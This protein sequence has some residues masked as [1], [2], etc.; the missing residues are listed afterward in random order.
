[1]NLINVKK[2][3]YFKLA[4]IFLLGSIL[5]TWYEV[6]LNLIISGTLE[7]RSSVF[8]GPFNVIYGFAFLMAVVLFK[9]IKRSSNLILLGALLGGFIEYL[10]SLL[11]ELITGAVSWDYSD[12]FLN[13]DGRTTLPFMLYWGILVW[14]GVRKLYPLI[15]KLVDLIPTKLN[16]PIINIV[17]F[18]LIINIIFSSAVFIRRGLRVNGYQPLTPIGEYFDT[19]FNDE[20]ILKYYPNLIIK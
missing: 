3:N 14:L 11:Q 15:I 1:M 7:R 16:K 18:L 20:T 5:G 10:A 13:I 4:W 19:Y 12:L 17:M 6:I 2:I 8:V 9:N